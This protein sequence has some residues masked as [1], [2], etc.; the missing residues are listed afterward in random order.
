M[1]GNMFI[2]FKEFKL[3]KEHIEIFADLKELQ[4]LCLVLIIEKPTCPIIIHIS[5]MF[6]DF[7]QLKSQ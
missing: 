2:D 3:S 5:D 1:Q 7:R 4:I 6:I